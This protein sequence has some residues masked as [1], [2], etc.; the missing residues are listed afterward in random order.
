MYLSTSQTSTEPITATSYPA[1]DKH[2]PEVQVSLNGHA[3][4]FLSPAEAAEL[5]SVLTAALAELPAPVGA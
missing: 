2:A 5:L 4:L 1:T 3:Q